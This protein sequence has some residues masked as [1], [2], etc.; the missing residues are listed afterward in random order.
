MIF[1]LYARLAAAAV[2][3]VFLMG[4][5]WKAYSSGKAAITAEWQADIAQR[6]A[7]AL[8][9]SEQARKVEQELSR[10][11][12]DVTTSYHAARKNTDHVAAAAAVGMRELQAILAKP[13]AGASDTATASGV[14]DPRDGIIARC[15]V[16]LVGVDAAYRKLADKNHAL[17][18]YT[19]GVCVKP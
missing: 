19:A 12:R 14:D 4:T 17:Q 7:E 2:V 10:K 16:A 3:A 13:I 11:V 1:S 5:H 18:D 6:T 9:A 15:A 8:A